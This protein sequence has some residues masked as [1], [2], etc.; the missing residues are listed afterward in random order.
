MATEKV[1]W[2]PLGGFSGVVQPT[3]EDLSRCVHCG[4]CL[5]YCPTYR[6]TGLETES[7]RGRIYLMRNVKDG[8]LD[9]NDAFHQHMDL[10]LVCRA[11]ETACPSGVRFGRMM[12]ATRVQLWDRPV[13][14]LRQRFAN[15]FAFELLFPHR[16]VFRLAFRGLQLYQTS[17]L[18][19]L[20]RRSGM[21]RR[22]SPDLARQEALLPPLQGRFFD[23]QPSLLPRREGGRPR[24]GF[25]AGCVMA[26]AFGDVQRASVRVLERLGCQVVTP[27]G[28]GCCGALNVHAGERRMAQQMARALIESMLT[29]DVDVVVINSAGCGS[30]MKEYHEL[31]AEE[32]EY[33]PRVREFESKVQDF[34][35]Y[36][37]SLPAAEMLAAGGNG[38]REI[39][40]VYQDACHLRHAQ[41]VINQPR[42]LLSRIP[43]LRLVELTYPDQCCGSAGV[44]NLEHPELSER[45]LRAKV[46]DLRASG[47]ELIISANPGCILQIQKGLRESGMNIPVKHIAV[48][49]DEALNGVVPG[50]GRG[51]EWRG[52]G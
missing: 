27:P 8:R 11:C 29:A 16:R 15:R 9:I 28:Q 47:A 44:Y 12:E 30:T 20:V 41:R 32:P 6:A 48:V 36:L 35:E 4:L 25:V 31:F 17:G 43:Y 24:V 26:T 1:S 23:V 7:P 21:L 14:P 33:L 38:R 40:A 46:D 5:N 50:S 52:T 3:D 37:A 42:S 51:L 34:S 45:I 39:R 19:G 2:S 13:G 18:Q 10:C 49:L 22:L